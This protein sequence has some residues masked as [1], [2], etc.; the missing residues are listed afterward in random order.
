M[1]NLVAVALALIWVAVNVNLW[2]LKQDPQYLF[3]ESLGMA[4]IA[5]PALF[6]FVSRTRN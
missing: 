3:W 2:S 1:A 4:G 6:W 5:F